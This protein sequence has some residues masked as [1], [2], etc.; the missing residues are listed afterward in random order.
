MALSLLSGTARSGSDLEIVHEPRPRLRLSLLPSFELLSEDG[1]VDLP[2]GPQRVVA[3]LAL[4]PGAVSRSHVAGTLWPDSSEERANASLRSALWR[5]RRPGPTVVESTATHLRLAPSVAVDVEETTALV[6]RLV[7]TSGRGPL[8]LADAELSCDL[9]TDWYDDWLEVDRERFRQLRLHALEL[10]CERLAEARR[11]S[12]AV[13]AGLTAV[14][15]EPLRES[16]HRALVKAHLAEGNVGEAIRQYQSYRTLL[17]NE[18]GLQPSPLFE[19]LVAAL[20]VA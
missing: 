18:L 2:L 14:A 9:L 16:A 20:P 17:A 5:L 4:Q 11:F 13:Q 8:D 15:A 1:V 7:E 6:R 19:A 10:L 12:A 3:L